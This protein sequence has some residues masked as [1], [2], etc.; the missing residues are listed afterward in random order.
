MDKIANMLVMIKNAGSAGKPAIRSPY[1]KYKHTIADFLVKQGYAVSAS[2][3]TQEGGFPVLEV[4][5]KYTGGSPA[6]SN[7][8]RVS[9][10]SRRLYFGVKD[11]HKVRNGYGLLALSTP[12]GILTGAEARKEQVGGEALF[13]IW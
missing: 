12:K 6:I 1:S 10:P 9:K 5:L 13:K 7:I 4:E 3:K 11:I 8:A 2:K